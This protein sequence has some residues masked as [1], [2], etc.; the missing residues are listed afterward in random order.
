MDRWHTRAVFGPLLILAGIVFLLESLGVVTFGAWLASLAFAAGGLAFLCV[1]LTNRENWWAT[2][3]AMA[4]LGIAATIGVAEALPEA[5]GAWAG[6]VFFVVLSLAFGI[7]YLQK[8]ENWWAI[9]PAGVMLSLA[10]VV[11]LSIV[12]S[13]EVAAGSLFL[14]LGGTFAL[15]SILPT[16]EGR[17]RWALIPAAV[18]LVFGV[19]FIA[20]FTPLLGYVW[21]LAL[22]AAG[23]YLTY[24]A[25][26]PRRAR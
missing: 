24:A 26:H 3:P 2:I 11:I 7:I 20:A 19:L 9:I 22:I 14:G 17:L 15:L 8:R 25:L 5:D 12:A 10:G 18:L 21:P 13:G 16:P 23:L 1:F 4:L 6:A